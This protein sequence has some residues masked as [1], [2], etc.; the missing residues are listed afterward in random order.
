MK[1]VYDIINVVTGRIYHKHLFA[2]KLFLVIIFFI[3]YYMYRY[4]KHTQTIFC[5][6]YICV[7]SKP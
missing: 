6:C 5:K 4:V 1:N 7:C 3:P 2:L